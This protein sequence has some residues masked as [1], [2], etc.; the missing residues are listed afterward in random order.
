MTTQDKMATL[1]TTL[2]QLA[3]SV[4]AEAPSVNRQ[5][6]AA[7]AGQWILYDGKVDPVTTSSGGASHSYEETVVF[8]GQGATA[9]HRLHRCP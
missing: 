5:A 1:R 7:L 4:K 9:G 3:A 6:M 2:D 8:D